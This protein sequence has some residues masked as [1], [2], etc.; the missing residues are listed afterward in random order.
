[1]LRLQQHLSACGPSLKHML[2]A[3]NVSMS[4]LESAIVATDP[5]ISTCSHLQS[6]HICLRDSPCSEG[7]AVSKQVW[8][9]SSDLPKASS[10]IE[11]AQWL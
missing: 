8:G 1:M 5:V 2:L 6:F 11:Q 9:S 10:V 7:A 3:A 4:G